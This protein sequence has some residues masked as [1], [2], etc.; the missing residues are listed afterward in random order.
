MLD[1]Q[2]AIARLLDAV[3][4]FVTRHP[5]P[6]MRDT[7]LPRLRVWSSMRATPP[8]PSM[9][10]PMFYV[11]L[12]GTKVL[13]IGG[14]KLALSTGDCAAS[15]FGMPY[16]GE[17]A[18]ASP[19]APY[20]A[21]SLQLD[22]GMLA[23][24]M[25]DMPR[26]EDRWVCSAAGGRLTGALGDAFCRFVGLAGLPEDLAM[27]GRPYETELY[28][29]LLQ[30]PMGDTLRQ[31]GPRDDRHRQIKVAADWLQTNQDKPV[32]VSELAE[33]VGMSLTSFHRHFKAVTGYSPL[34]FQ[35]QIRLL[36]ARRLL[37]AGGVSVSR[38]AYAVGYQ[39]P[40]QFSREYKSL[41]GTPPADDLARPEGRSGP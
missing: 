21:I 22:V 4:P 11:V 17:V 38:V 14:T 16:V 20:I 24:V 41:F 39:S 2:P 25:L 37:A 36:E 40:S 34:A 15:S 31:L 23:N 33:S 12:Q 13:T 26:V 8:V 29:R 7:P 19:A 5:G 9:F 30:S 3:T 18:E 28:Y 32:V 35:R 6:S 1:T 27:L 10:E